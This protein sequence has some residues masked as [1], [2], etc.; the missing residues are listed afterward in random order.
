MRGYFFT[1]MYLSSIQKGIQPAHCIGE[2]S[3]KYLRLKKKAKR[4][5][6][7]RSWLQKHKTMIVLDGGFSSH[8]NELATFFADKN[9][10]YPWATFNEGEEEL[11][12]ALTCVG[13]VLPGK[14]YEASSEL[15]TALTDEERE[16]VLRSGFSEWE[17]A[18][19]EALGQYRLAI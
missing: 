4:S 7:L 16:T 14:V 18:L 12:G 2:L 19:I 11:N 3:I 13:I 10:P 5:D 6:I 8:L 17:K 9:N 1:N 15:R